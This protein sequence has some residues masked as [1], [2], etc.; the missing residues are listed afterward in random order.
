MLA[1]PVESEIFVAI[2]H[3][4]E[5]SFL[6]FGQFHCAISSKMNSLL[7]ITMINIIVLSRQCGLSSLLNFVRPVIDGQADP[8]GERQGRLQDTQNHNRL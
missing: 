6:R 8:R 4:E 1:F 5:F 3:W 2:K 7:D